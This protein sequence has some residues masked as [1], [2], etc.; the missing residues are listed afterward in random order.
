MTEFSPITNNEEFRLRCPKKCDA[1]NIQYRSVEDSQG[2][3]DYQ[4]RCS[5]CGFTWWVDGS[6]Y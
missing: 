3:E 4:Y 2:H 1:P 5:G 6:D